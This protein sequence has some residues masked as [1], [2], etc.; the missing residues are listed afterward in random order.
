MPWFYL[1]IKVIHVLAAIV[2]VGFNATYAIWLVRAQRD[3]AHLEF[4]LRGVKFLDDYIANP[5]Y[6]VLFISGLAMFFIGRYPLNT[7]W[8]DAA[9]A[10][11]VIVAILGYGFYT[12]TLSRQIKAL[13]ASGVESAEY[14]ALSA[15]GSIVG[16]ALGAI[17]AVIVI[18]MVFKPIL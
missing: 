18:L 2:A 17:V 8:L 4:A 15:R 6:I 16:S 11:F 9:M 10:L 5:A 12:P 1:S 7:F 14:R 3:P 13:A